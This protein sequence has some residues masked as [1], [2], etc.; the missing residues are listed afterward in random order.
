MFD[1][2][3]VNDSTLHWVFIIWT[4]KINDSDSDSHNVSS[5]ILRCD[6]FISLAKIVDISSFDKSQI[7]YYQLEHQHPRSIV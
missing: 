5:T 7:N 1:H 2:I 3:F 4:N 6:C